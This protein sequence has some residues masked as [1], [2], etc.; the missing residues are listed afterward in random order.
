MHQL[1]ESV[2]RS[3]QLPSTAETSSHNNHLFWY[4]CKYNNVCNNDKNCKEGSRLYIMHGWVWFPVWYQPISIAA[5]LTPKRQCCAMDQKSN[6]QSLIS[7]T[8]YLRDTK[9]EI[10]F[11]NHLPQGLIPK[12]LS[13]F[14]VGCYR[15]RIKTA[16]LFRIV[17]ITNSQSGENVGVSRPKFIQSSDVYRVS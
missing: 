16:I 17:I 2:L 6:F 8:K 9:E 7:F 1:K 11:S 10:S 15:L 13:L 3:A 4:L 12:A 14:T 5:L